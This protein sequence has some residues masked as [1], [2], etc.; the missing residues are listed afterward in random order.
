MQRQWMEPK[1]QKP[2][3]RQLERVRALLKSGE[4]EVNRCCVECRTTL[5]W[6]RAEQAALARL[7]AQAAAPRVRT[8]WST[9]ELEQWSRA[10]PK[11]LPAR[12]VQPRPRK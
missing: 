10:E 7:D 3:A 6:L 2:S 1:T 8:T 12:P 4:G 11:P 9:Q 5:K